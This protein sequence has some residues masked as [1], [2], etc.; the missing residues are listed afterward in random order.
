MKTRMWLVIL[1]LALVLASVQLTFAAPLPPIGHPVQSGSTILVPLDAST[2]TV[3]LLTSTD[4]SISRFIVQ[5]KVKDA[6]CTQLAT[7]H[8]N[9]VQDLA[10]V[11][12]EAPFVSVSDVSVQGIGNNSPVDSF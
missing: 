12:I 11:I 9:T 10:V 3:L 2:R 4:P 5:Y 8:G 1:N 6:I 7:R